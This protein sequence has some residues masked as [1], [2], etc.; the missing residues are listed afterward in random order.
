MKYR[1]TPIRTSK[2]K[3]KKKKKEKPKN[4]PADARDSS[5]SP[6]PGK[7]HMPQNNLVVFFPK[8]NKAHPS[9][10]HACLV[11]QNGFEKVSK[12]KLSCNLCTAAL[13][14][15]A[16]NFQISGCFW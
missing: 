9:I 14:V 2:L 1:S 3:K 16:K 13:L 7:S 6:Y 8:L 12:Q 10:K 15:I 11:F 4:P 5:L